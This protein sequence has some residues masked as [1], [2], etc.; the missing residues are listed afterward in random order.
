MHCTYQTFIN[1]LFNLSK[2][3]SRSFVQSIYVT[4]NS[5]GDEQTLQ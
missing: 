2:S 4:Y 1:Q 5:V 3:I